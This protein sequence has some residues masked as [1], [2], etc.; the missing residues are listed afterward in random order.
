M[1]LFSRSTNPEDP[2][3]ERKSSQPTLTLT[4]ENAALL[5]SGSS[6]AAC[7]PIQEEGGELDHREGG[8]LIEGERKREDPSEVA[9]T[10]GS[11]RTDRI[12]LPAD[13]LAAI[14]ARKHEGNMVLMAKKE[15][16]YGPR[17]LKK[18]E[19]KEERKKE[20]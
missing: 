12:K 20:G 1:L 11:L 13:E 6:D 2:G 17:K 9:E 8:H 5:P 3:S 15:Y 4:P 7:S 18:E 14:A 19:K 16:P 10:E